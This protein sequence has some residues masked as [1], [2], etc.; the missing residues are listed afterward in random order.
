MRFVLF[1]EGYTE[2]EAA[3]EFLKRWLDPQL[4]RPVGVKIVRFNGWHQFIDDVAA[5]ARMYLEGPG[6]AEIISALGLLDLY[7]PTFYPSHLRSAQERYA[8]AVTEI[9]RKV[10][11]PK[12]RMFFAVH[13]LEAWILSQ[14]Q[15]LPEAVQ[16]ALPGRV[17]NPESI[18]FE[19]PP[20]K[21]LERLYASHTGRSYKKRTYGSELFRKLDPSVA[22]KKC[23]HLAEML[24]HML[25]T[26]RQAAP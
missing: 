6:R 1:V 20:A 5:R 15:L 12:F 13:E 4:A 22:C 23:P 21:L 7:G 2:R 24:E 17:N 25:T 11:H 14:P 18:D 8:W 26:A 16:Q 9:E 10:S 3:G 19:E